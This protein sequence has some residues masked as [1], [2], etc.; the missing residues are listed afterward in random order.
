[1]AAIEQLDAPQRLAA[2]PLYAKVREAL[3]GRLISGI[4]K[5]GQMLPS[6]FAIAD[7]LGVSQG[8]VRKALDEMT[9]QGLLIRRQGRGT[10]VNES[11]D[12]SI[13]F[14]FYRL[15][16]D[17]EPNAESRSFPQSKYLSRALQS[18]N[19][20][21][22]DLFNLESGAQVWHFER[23]RSENEQPILVE[24]LVLPQNRF[25]DLDEQKDLPN[26]VYRFY[27]AQYGIIV[28]R[29]EEKLRAVTAPAHV[30][31]HLGLEANAPVLE[32]DRRAY[33]LDG[34]IVEWRVSLCRS[35]T[36]HYRNELK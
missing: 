30:S 24:K 32:I 10:F 2:Q 15:T 7:E 26:N 11:E 9:S 25:P 6:E 20:Q 8:T 12:K 18:A 23:L 28:A 31:K 17:D 19:P 29:V 5:P 4:W 22:Q 33:A 36:M 27:G 21:E 14:R 35:D 1:M 16:S 34:N 13:L 3:V